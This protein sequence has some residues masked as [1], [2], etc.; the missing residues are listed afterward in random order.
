MSVPQS[1]ADIIAVLVWIA[2]PGAA[3]L[4]AWGYA[5]LRVR[6]DL[7]PWLA[8]VLDATHTG[9]WLVPALA[10]AIAPAAA[11]LAALLAGLPPPAVSAIDANLPLLVQALAGWVGAKAAIRVAG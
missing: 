3:I 11:A 1:V 2:G 5:E 4:L 9:E 10:A 7:P 6:K 8:G